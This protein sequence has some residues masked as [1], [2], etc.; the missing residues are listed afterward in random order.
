M[1]TFTDISQIISNLKHTDGK[2]IIRSE[3]S[4][5]YFVNLD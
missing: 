3:E 1:T 4:E 5:I 2:P